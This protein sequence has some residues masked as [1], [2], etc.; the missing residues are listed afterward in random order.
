MSV[1]GKALELAGLRWLKGTRNCSLVCTEYNY[2]DVSGI[3]GS[4][5]IEIEIKRTKSDLRKDKNKKYF[6]GI[7]KHLAMNE[8]HA[9]NYFY[10]LVPQFLKDETLKE[11][12]K[13]N[14]KYGVLYLKDG[15]GY[16]E[17]ARRGFRLNKNVLSDDKRNDMMQRLGWCYINMF[18][19]SEQL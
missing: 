18:E 6:G 12:G 8:Y 4:D 16:P 9:P 5:R 13:L 19:K 7:R 11:A 2:E 1:N 14:K 3:K 15:Y 10:F 17:I